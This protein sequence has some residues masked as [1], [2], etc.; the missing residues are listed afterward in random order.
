MAPRVEYSSAPFGAGGQPNDVTITSDPSGRYLLLTY[1]SR[2][3]FFTGWINDSKLRLL[4]IEQP[5]REFPIPA[6]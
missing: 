4:K 2:A 1:G 3:G 5:Y 6:W